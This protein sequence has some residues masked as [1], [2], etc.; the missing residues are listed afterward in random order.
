MC[1][2][3]STNY[4]DD[5][6]YQGDSET[7]DLSG[8]WVGQGPRSSPFAQSQ[9]QRLTSALASGKIR[10]IAEKERNIFIDMPKYTQNQRE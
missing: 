5:I 8:P 10:D 3:T 2:G 7:P 1:K 6:F 4:M 9:L